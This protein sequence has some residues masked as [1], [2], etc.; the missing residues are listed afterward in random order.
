VRGLS[1]AVSRALLLTVI[2][3]AHYMCQVLLLV[4]ISLPRHHS[5]KKAT[6]DDNNV[7]IFF[8]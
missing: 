7:L 3:I 2:L 8:S 6:D 5:C 4:S 1:L